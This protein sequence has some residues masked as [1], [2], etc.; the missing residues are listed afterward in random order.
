MMDLQPPVARVVRDGVEVETPVRRC[1][2]GD[3]VVVRPGERIPVDGAV[4][5]RRIGGGRIDADG[6]EH[7]GG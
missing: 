6:R 1:V 4:L 7:A 5:R 2:P 3:M